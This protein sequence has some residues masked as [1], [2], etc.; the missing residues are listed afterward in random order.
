MRLCLCLCASENSIRQ[1]TGFV[2]MFLLMLTLMSRVFSLVMLMLCLCASEN[3]PLAALHFIGAWKATLIFLLVSIQVLFEWPRQ[4]V[5]SCFNACTKKVIFIFMLLIFPKT[6]TTIFSNSL[7]LHQNVKRGNH[8]LNW[9]RFFSNFILH[10]PL[11]FSIR[12]YVKH[13]RQCLTTFPNM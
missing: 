2:L 4:R 12:R 1:I 7:T 10:F 8:D 6:F 13:P 11:T 9:H 5:I 3:Q